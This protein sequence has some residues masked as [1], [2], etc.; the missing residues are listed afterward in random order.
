[1]AVAPPTANAAPV[2]ASLAEAKELRARLTVHG[3]LWSG[4]SALP[5]SQQYD[6]GLIRDADGSVRIDMR[7]WTRPLGNS[8]RLRPVAVTLRPGADPLHSLSDGRVVAVPLT[9]TVLRHL[10][11]VPPGASRRSSVPSYAERPPR[12]TASP[13]AAALLAP[14]E[15]TVT[16][17][18]G[19]RTRSILVSHWGAG[20]RIDASRTRFFARRAD[21]QFAVVFDERIGAIVEEELGTSNGERYTTYLRYAPIPGGYR[22]AERERVVSTP[23]GSW[24]FKEE[25]AAPQLVE[26]VR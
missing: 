25:I 2:S 18:V 20:S 12:S 19:A 11:P 8:K 21:K 23:R 26:D 10:I 9:D 3:S 13:D 1:L 17:A 4:A 6:V 22:L 16:A 24:R 14:I 5:D 7:S 15:R